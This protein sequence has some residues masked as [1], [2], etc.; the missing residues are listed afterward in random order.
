M[1]TIKYN[2]VEITKILTIH[3]DQEAI[4]DE[5]NTNQIGTKWTITGQGLIH[6]ALFDTQPQTQPIPAGSSHVEIQKHI[7]HLLMQQ[8]HRFEL[9]HVVD[10]GEDEELL[11]ECDPAPGARDTGIDDV[12]V[13]PDISGIDINNGPRALRIELTKITPVIYT[14][15]FT[16][17]VSKAN[18]CDSDGR[19]FNNTGMLSVSFS[20][21]DERNKNSMTR[22]IV[23]GQIRSATA[24][25]NPHSFRYFSMPQLPMGMRFEEVSHTSSKDGLLLDF[26]IVMQEDYASPPPPAL[27]WAPHLKVTISSGTGKQTYV[28]A[29]CGLQGDRHANRKLLLANIMAILTSRVFFKEDVD[30]DPNREGGEIRTTLEQ[31]VITETITDDSASV[32]AMMRGSR[33]VFGPD[34][35][36]ITTDVIGKDP[37]H[38]T[39][40]GTPKEKNFSRPSLLQ[41]DTR[42]HR[43]NWT[44]DFAGPDESRGSTEETEGAISV[45]SAFSAY[46]QNECSR[47]RRVTSGVPGVEFVTPNRRVL[48]EIKEYTG[49]V[50]EQPPRAKRVTASH[51]N[52]PYVIW[53]AEVLYDITQHVVSHPIARFSDD[54]PSS[55]D[56]PTVANIVLAPPTATA[57]FRI[58]G[59][60]IGKPP[61]M[62][63]PKSFTDPETQ[64]VY[65]L[66]DFQ[67][68]P[69]TPDQKPGGDEY[70]VCGIDIRYSCSRPPR[71]DERV[72]IGQNPWDLM[73]VHRT[74]PETGSD[75]SLI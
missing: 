17:E 28:A 65:T 14:C 29:E 22:R 19:N 15:Q 6:D 66:L 56:R 41:W 34:V 9:W 55:A 27:S 69:Q 24:K 4:F 49:E 7:R 3:T 25:I 64:I 63:V 67:V 23:E 51:A 60:R 44:R 57:T 53:R 39:F 73:G 61:V 74:K 75:S 59:S 58:R 10:T 18:E 30:A 50:V 54:S 36:V 20:T 31:L 48:P 2:G 21:T 32:F 1:S 43:G 47:D 38:L 11:L 71:P 52:S 13:A 70:H 40:E 5:S 42:L 26:K 37:R 46:L 12:I 16:F 8:R 33:T 62:P 72:L 68:V 35:N 45:K